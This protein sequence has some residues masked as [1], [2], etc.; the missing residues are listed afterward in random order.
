MLLFKIHLISSCKKNKFIGA[1]II[2]LSSS[3]IPISILVKAKH[4][5]LKALS[6]D[7]LLSR[8]RM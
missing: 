3:D 1:K 4:K 6:N 2:S 5:K 8:L 7:S